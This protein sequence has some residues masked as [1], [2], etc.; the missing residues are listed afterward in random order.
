M[1]SDSTSAKEKKF[2]ALKSSLQR[3]DELYYRQAQ[4]EISDQEYDRLKRD[5]ERLQSE[6]DPLGLFSEEKVRSGVQ[7]EEVAL[8]VGDDR[9]DSFESHN[10]AEVML[11]LDNTYDQSEFFDFD[12]RLKKILDEDCLT[13]VV[14]PKIDGVAVSLSYEKGK[15]QR[16]VTRGNGVQGDVITQNILHLSELPRE[17]IS[18]KI[19]DFIE[20]RGEIYMEHDEFLRINKER[21]E[22]GEAL[23][24]NPRNLAA[25]TVKLLDPKEAKQRKLKVVLYGLGACQPN[26]YFQTQTS[27]HEALKDWCFP[28]VEFVK[29]VTSVENAW[30]EICRLDELRH[31]YAYPTDGA[32]IKLDSRDGQEIAGRTAKAPRWAIAYK[33]ES[34]RQMTKLEDIILQVGRTGAITPVACLQPVQLA[35]T[36]VSRA[37]L[38][39][40]DEIQR[41]DI[42]IGDCV[43]VEKAGEII[44]QVVEVV[45]EKRPE[46]LSPFDFPEQ[47]PTC[48]NPLSRTKGEAAW[49]CPN[50]NC[51]DQ[52]KGRIEYF[53]SRGCLDI[54]NLGE[55][56]V[57]QL[58]D[59]HLVASLDDLYRLD[60]SQLLALEG[61]ADKSANNLI[62][63]I[64]RS[65]TQDFWR[66]LCGLGI[67]HVGTSASKDLA[68]T[69]SDWRQ[70]AEASLE[71]FTS[72]D[73][74]GEIMAESLVD[75]FQNPLNLSMLESLESLGV[76]LK[77]DHAEALSTPWAGVTF[78]LTGSLEKF[79]RQD[80]TLQIEKFGG[81]VSSSV[82]KKTSYV[83]A[84]PGAGSK[85]N[86]A[87]GLDIPILSE[88]QFLSFLEETNSKEE[89]K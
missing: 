1:S 71:D 12:K 22:S 68:R 31:G 62:D 48:E 65:K 88:D 42:R 32:V 72:I 14:E 18:E 55:A 27:F 20:I 34:E 50:Q 59:S 43:V 56:V 44:P 60:S 67:K 51:P 53:A 82:S 47:C 74:I 85:L 25:G 76:V 11:S 3:H 29:T 35:G 61:F 21:E 78:V 10:H 23:Y 57:G 17:I 52:L 26:D 13:Y 63:A 8:K 64:E 9:L 19:P 49:R 69:F 81:K 89:A 46:S 77:N 28:V 83:V 4:P 33:F 30:S 5:F 24:A 6:V 37:S 70:L 7:L 40:A 87:Q 41:K 86:K 36:L 58:V 15:L 84:G 16:A 66:I 39:N 45:M 73:G 2:A 75:F 79:S 54:E 80:A 38:H